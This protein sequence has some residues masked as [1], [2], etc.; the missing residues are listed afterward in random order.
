MKWLMKSDVYNI[1][2]T[3]GQN[4]K[5]N[6]S[7]FGRKKKK[8]KAQNKTHKKS[9]TGKNSVIKLLGKVTCRR[10]DKSIAQIS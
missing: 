4:S 3:Y 10:V 6:L 8:K 5:R 9:S 2:C 1:N 7:G